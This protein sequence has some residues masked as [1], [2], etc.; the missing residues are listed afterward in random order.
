MS[1]SSGQ[2]SGM[3]TSAEPPDLLGRLLSSVLG[4]I[5]TLQSK[6][7]QLPREGAQA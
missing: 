4:P 1:T 3:V 6:L 7:R 2:H 5:Q